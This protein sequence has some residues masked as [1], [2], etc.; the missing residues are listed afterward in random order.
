MPLI[1][2]YCMNVLHKE[3]DNEEITALFGWPSLSKKS[4]IINMLIFETKWHIWK[5]RNNVKYGKKQPLNQTIMLKNI[6]KA[7]TDCLKRLD[8]NALELFSSNF[9]LHE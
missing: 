6:Q 9:S 1:D 2:N 3:I 5:D 7:V 8:K 4:I